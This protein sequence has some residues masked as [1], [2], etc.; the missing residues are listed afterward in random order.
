M[1]IKIKNDHPSVFCPNEKIFYNFE[2]PL[3][4]NQHPLI[5]KV[6]NVEVE[7]IKKSNQF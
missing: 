6:F 7:I 2:I 3:T 4:K 1:E 5:L